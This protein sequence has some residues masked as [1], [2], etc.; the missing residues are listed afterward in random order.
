MNRTNTKYTL[1]IKIPIKYLQDIIKRWHFSSF[2]KS[3]IGIPLSGFTQP[4]YLTMTTSQVTLDY[5]FIKR[6]KQNI[7][8]LKMTKFILGNE[9]NIHF[10]INVI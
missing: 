7:R 10:T 5:V 4:R 8:L 3:G 6:N 9:D 1:I 2:I